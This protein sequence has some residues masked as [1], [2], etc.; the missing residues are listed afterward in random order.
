ML[1]RCI[2][3]PGKWE[4]VA[5]LLDGVEAADATIFRH[6]GRYWMTSVVRDGCGGYSDTLALHHAENIFGRWE[7]HPM[8][9]VIVD[10]RFARPAGSVVFHNG[11]LLRPV[12]DC[13]E[14]Y[15]RRLVIMRI[16][17]LDGRD[18]RQTPVA[19]IEPGGAWPGRRLH[20]INRSG[21]L[22]CI[23][24]AILA[25]KQKPLRRMIAEAADARAAENSRACDEA[26]GA[27]ALASAAPSEGSKIPGAM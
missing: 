3:F 22:E 25:P 9:P 24:G 19:T 23:D 5:K 17:Q 15:G 2:E 10:S 14:G 11:A 21:R 26:K 18:F 12:Q 16:D 8:S 27:P 6:G 7:P 13:S 20:T 4:P 1:Y